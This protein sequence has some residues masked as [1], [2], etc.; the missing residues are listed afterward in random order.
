[1]K[2]LIVWYQKVT[3]V[4]NL[5]RDGKTQYIQ[6]YDNKNKQ[7]INKKINTTWP[8]QNLIRFY[9]NAKYSRDSLF[10][11]KRCFSLEKLNNVLR[12]Q[13]WPGTR[14]M[15][16]LHRTSKKIVGHLR[17]LTWKPFSGAYDVIRLFLGV[18]MISLNTGLSL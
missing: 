8:I 14:N 2:Y 17:I 13:N 6:L 11:G 4:Q 18:N 9:L 7:E 5:I 1:M 3:I 16:S 15:A 12:S 10:T